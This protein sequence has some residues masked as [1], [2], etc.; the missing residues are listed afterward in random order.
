MKAIIIAA[1]LGIRLN[2]L[3][4]DTPKCMLEIKGKTILQHQLDVFHANDITDI[5]VRD[6]E[7][8]RSTA[9]HGYMDRTYISKMRIGFYN[10]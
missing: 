8:N 7:R 2:P 10:R 9:T 3:T 1:G 4:N 5:S 6:S